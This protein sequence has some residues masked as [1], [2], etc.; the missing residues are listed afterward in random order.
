V[1][2]NANE[3]LQ[4]RRASKN[5]ATGVLYTLSTLHWYYCRYIIVPSLF[6]YYNW[7]LSYSD[8]CRPIWL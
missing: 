2:L 1:D 3:N 7:L 4:F 6:V 5:F 8:W